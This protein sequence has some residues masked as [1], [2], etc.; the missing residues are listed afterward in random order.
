MS[1]LKEGK[2][3]ASGDLK[4][5]DDIAE[6]LSRYRAAV[7]HNSYILRDI[8]KVYAFAMRGAIRVAKQVVNA[9]KGNKYS[10]SSTKV[11]GKEVLKSAVRQ[12]KGSP[13]S[14][15]QD[16]EVGQESANLV[17]DASDYIQGC[18]EGRYK[19]DEELFN[20]CSAVVL[21][22]A[23]AN[24]APKKTKFFKV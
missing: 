5:S 4:D 22:A 24:A 20:E 9:D 21:E 1:S 6:M 11:N 12:S 14:A 16:E 19:L 13:N 15:Y 18:L 2:A 23:K 17:N 3:I 8:S 7:M 10:T